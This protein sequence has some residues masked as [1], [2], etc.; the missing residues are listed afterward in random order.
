MLQ[1][2]FRMSL[3]LLVLLLVG[4]RG[5]DA[6]HAAASRWIHGNGF[7]TPYPSGLWPKVNGVATVF[8]VID[9][10]SDPK[11]T[12]TIK[13]AIANFNADFPGV[14]QWVKWT[15][16]QKQSPNYVDINLSASITSGIC[17]AL[18]GY[19]GVPAQPMWGSGTCTLATIMHEMGHVVGL[20]HEQARTDR[21]SYVNVNYGNVI[22]GSWSY[23]EQPTD[24]F[25]LLTPYDYASLM[26]YPPFAFTRN[27]GP[28]IESI[29]AGIPLGGE[30][31]PAAPT[32]YSAADQ[33]A[34]LRL[35]GAA[36]TNV[37][38]TSNPVGLSVTVDGTAVTTPHT[39]AWALNSTHALSVPSGVQTLSGVIL[40]TK[41]KATFYYTYGRWSDSTAQT[42]TISV[43]PGNGELTFPASSPMIATYAANFI[44]LVPYRAAISPA[45]SGK[46]SVSPAP[47]SYPGVK[48][49]FFIARQLVTLT[50][51]PAPGYAFYEFNNAPFWLPGGLGLNPKPV[52][53]PDTGNPV[54][55]TVEFSNGPVY[56]VS[57]SPDYATSNL[58]VV[59]DN[60]FAY[61]PK[62]FSPPYDSSWTT[63]SSHVLSFNS[64]NSPHSVNTRFVFESWNAGSPS[65]APAMLRG[66]APRGPAARAALASRPVE[67]AAVRLRTLRTTAPAGGGVF[68]TTVI[69]PATSTAYTATIQPQYAP[70]TNFGFPPCGGTA[71]ISPASPTQDGFYPTGQQLS[72][73]A[74]AGSGWTFAGWTFDLGGTTNPASLVAADE[75]L[76]F[77]NFNTSATPLTVT[78]LSPASATSGS[79]G[80]TLTITGTGFNTGSL[81]SF[82]GS[83]RTPTFVNSTQLTIP[84]SAADV[85]QAGAFQVFVENFP[86]G[87]TGCA[88]FGYWP[89]F[90]A[91]S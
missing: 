75:T 41:R 14:I 43:A 21:A 51:T 39:F 24:N 6:R 35:Y 10:A 59:V 76:V 88:V 60:T 72:F 78:G 31:T 53:V 5:V 48:G 71:S 81:V 34:I 20:W 86:A 44:Q 9:S 42:R 69:L 37:T 26:E 4:V 79:S 22:K 63:G 70:A 58:S 16:A 49:K 54:D 45:A 67:T 85:A 18:E 68:S 12:P 1:L 23:F 77:A 3:A 62:N 47:K 65:S 36:P 19:E 13:T 27:G 64:P 7:G 55:T 82:N 33:E 52:Y 29:P 11:A 2:L 32:N 8:Y 38:V 74:T 46:V 66:F 25:Q 30:G 83:Y 15:A 87:S 61:T 28:P 91:A 73:G 56:S 50:A 17:E 84:L 90:V 89:F 40:G 80:F 57:L